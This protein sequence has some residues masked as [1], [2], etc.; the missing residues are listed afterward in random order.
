MVALGWAVTVAEK[1]AR[2]TVRD[3]EVGLKRYFILLEG[4]GGG[5]FFFLPFCGVGGEC[6]CLSI[7]VGEFTRVVICVQRSIEGLAAYSV[8]LIL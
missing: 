5:M 1:R 3:A 4:G 6:K 7:Y 8:I 2:A